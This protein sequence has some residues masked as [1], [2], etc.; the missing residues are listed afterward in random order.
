MTCFKPI[1]RGMK[2]LPIDLSVQFLPGT[3]EIVV[4]VQ[5][6]VHTALRGDSERIETTLQVVS[7]LTP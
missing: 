1:D 4:S 2:L 7:I 3:G 6:S 5:M